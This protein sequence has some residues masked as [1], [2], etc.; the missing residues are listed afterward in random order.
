MIL[1][2][3]ANII[4]IFVPYCISVDDVDVEDVDVHM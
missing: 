4:V 3:D 2:D 1:V